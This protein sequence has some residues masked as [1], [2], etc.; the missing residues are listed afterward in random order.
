MSRQSGGNEQEANQ[1]IFG[2]Q[3]GKIIMSKQ[4]FVGHHQ[5]GGPLETARAHPEKRSPPEIMR[6]RPP[7][8]LPEGIHPNMLKTRGHTCIRQKK[9]SQR[10]PKNP[11]DACRSNPG[12]QCGSVSR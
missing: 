3:L 6:R 8:I 10:D 7:Q 12:D 4:G 9:A 1:P 11:Y 2:K 5:S